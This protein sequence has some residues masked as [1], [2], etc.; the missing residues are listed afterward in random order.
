MSKD[1][2]IPVNEILEEIHYLQGLRET[3]GINEILKDG[4][5]RRAAVYS[6]QIISEA[7]RHLPD[8]WLDDYPAEPWSDIKRIGNRIRH[9]YFR[10]DEAVL[11]EVIEHDIDRL[12]IVMTEMKT[13]YGK[14][15]N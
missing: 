2:A 5:L 9:Q 10:L 15:D 1:P 12:E 4:T 7:T 11:W 14:R 13:R 8:S 3:S 6:I